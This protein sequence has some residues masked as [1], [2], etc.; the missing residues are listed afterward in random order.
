[1]R[2]SLAFIEYPATSV[3]KALTA[4]MDGGDLSKVTVAEQS[5]LFEM[6][7][8]KIS[9]ASQGDS[10]VYSE[11][12]LY[13]M[14]LVYDNESKEVIE[15]YAGTNDTKIYNRTERRELDC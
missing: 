7:D 9:Y 15:P 2:L 3:C 8:S 11:K 6:L 4:V 13:G 10:V 1:M 5:L 12:A 14:N